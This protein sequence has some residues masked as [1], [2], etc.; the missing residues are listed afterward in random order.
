MHQRVLVTTHVY[1]YRQN[2]CVSLVLVQNSDL[3]SRNRVF[4]IMLY[5]HWSP[6]FTGLKCNVAPSFFSVLSRPI[7]L[8]KGAQPHQDPAVV[9]ELLP[10]KNRFTSHFMLE[11][12]L[13]ALLCSW[14][15]LIRG[16]IMFICWPWSH[17][18]MSSFLHTTWQLS[19]TS[20]DLPRRKRAY[21][22]SGLSSRS[23]IISFFHNFNPHQKYFMVRT[24]CLIYKGSKDHHE[25]KTLISYA[26]KL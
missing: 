11:R 22:Q 6:L 14:I 13:E 19:S 17:F 15:W 26:Q 4:R 7:P 23:K 25:S 2:Y 1:N 18:A 12:H 21:M 16:S 10:P 8:S 9:Q 5:F 20:F 3:V 24:I